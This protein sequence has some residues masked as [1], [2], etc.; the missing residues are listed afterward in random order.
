MK[1]KKHNKYALLLGAHEVV[2]RKS[3]IHL[4][5][6]DAYQKVRLLLE[7]PLNFEHPKLEIHQINF[8]HLGR[9]TD[10]YTVDD[11]YFYW[12]RSMKIQDTGTKYDPRKT[13]AYQFA[14]LCTKAGAK[15]FVFLSSIAAD[16]DNVLT[17]RRE[18]WDLEEAIRSLPF[19]ATHIFRAGILLEDD[20]ASLSRRIIKNIADR[21][22]KMARGNLSKYKPI[23]ADKLAQMMVE[24]AQRFKAGIH[25]YSAEYIQTYSTEQNESIIQEN[26]KS[27]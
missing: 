14:D 25:N 5:R 4:L 10:L 1:I 26:G 11:V 8:E 13:Y 17:Y 24:Q 21:I 12:G 18:Q 15:Q 19:W 22:N 16:N 6:N 23:S 2:G 27:K 3:L 20:Q 9:Y 7:E